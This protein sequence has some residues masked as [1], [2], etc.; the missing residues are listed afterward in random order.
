MRRTAAYTVMTLLAA[1]LLQGCL[2]HEWPSPPG[3]VQVR[4][5]LEYDTGMDTTEH[6]YGTRAVSIPEGSD[7]RYIVRAFPL[8]KGSKASQ[9][10]A[11]EFVFSADASMGYDT[12]MTLELPEGDYSIM[13]WSDLVDDGSTDD[14]HYNTE[15]FS[16]ITLN[17]ES[18]PGNTDERDA[19]RGTG[20]VT[21]VSD[22]TERLPDTLHIAMERPLAKYEFIADDLAEFIENQSLMAMEQ[23]GTKSIDLEKY[24][25]V[26][27]YVGFMPDTYSLFTDKPVDSS[28]GVFFETGLTQIS[29]TEASLGFDYVFVNGQSSAVTVQIGIYGPGGGQVALTD[30]IEVPISR[31]THT[32]MRGG[33]LLSEAS[34]GISLNPDFDGDHNL[35]L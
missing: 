18:H 25:V 15:D 5:I 9:E 23:S 14:R 10:C 4:L 30:P 31:S 2:V 11:G 13:V 7:I 16:S 29:D 34:G 20:E 28:T 24:R 33:Y 12:E 32:V 27:Y 1:L 3:T 8:V 22:I 26:I 19:F 17:G 6:G 21:L 35:I